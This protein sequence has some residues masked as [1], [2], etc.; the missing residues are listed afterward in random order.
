MNGGLELVVRAEA[1]T[2]VFQPSEPDGLLGRNSS[3]KL[4]RGQ[5]IERPLRYLERV[6]LLGILTLKQTED[7]QVKS[8]GV[9]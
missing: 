2:E 3:V 9:V 7:V 5:H 4:A 6:D 8:R 1:R